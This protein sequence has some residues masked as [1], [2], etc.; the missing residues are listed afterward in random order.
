ML[1]EVALKQAAK[2]AAR[3][4]RKS[5]RTCGLGFSWA[6]RAPDVAADALDQLQL[7]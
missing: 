2:L 4:G 3:P 7:A 5:V 6:K 1:Y